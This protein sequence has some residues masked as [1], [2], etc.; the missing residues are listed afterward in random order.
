MY[1]KK[2]TNETTKEKR[3]I[4]FVQPFDIKRVITFSN[5]VLDGHS[6]I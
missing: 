1:T 6:L 4:P 3:Q 2:Y 5:T